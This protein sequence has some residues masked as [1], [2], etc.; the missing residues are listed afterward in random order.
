MMYGQRRGDATYVITCS[1][2]TVVLEQKA[3]CYNKVP[4]QDG[5]FMDPVT[6]LLS[7]TAA[8]TACIDR[9][10]LV[11]LA[12]NGKYVAIK[13]QITLIPAPA[14]DAPWEMSMKDLATSTSTAGIY[15][16]YEMNSYNLLTEFLSY[17]KA[18]LTGISMSACKNAECLHAM[19]DSIT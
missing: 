5:L 8:I 2:R 6:G 14:T 12:D 3:D 19:S 10:P 9:F 1:R 15:T 7:T 4:V 17:R 16:N 18:V 11:V 13:P